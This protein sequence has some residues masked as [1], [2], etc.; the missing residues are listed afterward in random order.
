MIMAQK[1]SC[2]KPREEKPTGE[3][4]VMRVVQAKVSS[5][6]GSDRFAAWDTRKE[7]KEHSMR[8]STSL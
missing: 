7:A 6:S 2:A 8:C 1:L 4:F 5:S 3:W